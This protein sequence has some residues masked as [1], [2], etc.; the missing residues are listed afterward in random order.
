MNWLNGS[1]VFEIR[2]G[3]W[4]RLRAEMRPMDCMDRPVKGMNVNRNNISACYYFSVREEEDVT[5]R[6][7]RVPSQEET[8]F[9]LCDCAGRDV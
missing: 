9:G 1:L 7:N 4:H 2:V 8:R 5:A 6:G 3:G